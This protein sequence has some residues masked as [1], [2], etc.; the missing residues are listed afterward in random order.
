MT[1]QT[2]NLKIIVPSTLF[3]KSPKM[4]QMQKVCIEKYEDLEI[5]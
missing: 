4:A 3:L 1:Q 5:R 2:K